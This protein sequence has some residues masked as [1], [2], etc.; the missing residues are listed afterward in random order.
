MFTVGRRGFLCGGI[1][2]IIAS[3]DGKVHAVSVDPV[4][5]IYF[6][7]VVYW[8]TWPYGT[9]RPEHDWAHGRMPL[10]PGVKQRLKRLSKAN[11]DVFFFKIE[12]VPVP[13]SP[14]KSRDDTA[15]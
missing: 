11:D 2:G 13:A 7:N 5:T 3:I 12:S 4:T 10:A 1:A 8:Q 9:D 15:Q 14:S 6:T